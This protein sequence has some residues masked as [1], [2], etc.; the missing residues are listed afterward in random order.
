MAAAVTPTA[1]VSGGT[2]GFE[3]NNR[4]KQY[5]EGLNTFCN[6]NLNLSLLK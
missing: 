5:F 3:F 1:I 6:L 4:G 2:T